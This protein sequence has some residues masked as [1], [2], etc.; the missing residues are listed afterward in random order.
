[1][2]IIKAKKEDLS[3]LNLLFFDLH[4]KH[5]ELYPEVFQ[6]ISQDQSIEILAE[7]FSNKEIRILVAEEGKTLLGYVMFRAKIKKQNSLFLKRSSMFIEQIYVVPK[8]R[9]NGIAKLLLKKVEMHAKECKIACVELDVWAANKEALDFFL[10][11]GYGAYNHLLC[12]K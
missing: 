11:V 10:N 9:Q 3:R 12:K 2:K 7:F 4:R 6:V 8:Y 5:V 1:M